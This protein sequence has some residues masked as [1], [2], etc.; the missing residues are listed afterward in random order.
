M[1]ENPEEAIRALPLD[2]GLPED[3]VLAEEEGDDSEQDGEEVVSSSALLPA[4]P[5]AEP[6]RKT[7]LERRIAFRLVYGSGPKRKCVQLKY[8]T[9]TTNYV[10]FLAG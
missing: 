5:R 7:A 4:P 6:K 9:T 10:L 8:Q 3:N 1:T 2:E